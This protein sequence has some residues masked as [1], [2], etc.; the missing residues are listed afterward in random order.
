MDDME[1][2]MNSPKGGRARDALF[3][4][5]LD[6]VAMPASRLAHQDRNMVGDILL[7]MLFHATTEERSLCASRLATSR[8]APRRLLRYL[9]QCSFEIAQPLLEQNEAFDACDL[10]EIVES[11]STEHRMAIA[12]RKVVAPGVSAALAE[13]GEPHVVREL[14]ANPGALLPESALDKLL[15]R[16]RDESQLCALMVERLELRPSQAMAMFWW[17][18]GATRRKILQRH[19]ADRLEVIETCKDVFEMMAAEKWA[20]PVARKALQLIERRQRNREALERSPFDSLES[21]IN[22]AAMEGMNAELAQE[23]GYLCGIK[24]VTIAKIL[25]DNGGEGLAVL[26]KATGVKR[27]FLPVLWASLRRPL[28]IDNDEMHPQF[29]IVAETY[30][31]LT[32]AKAQTTLRYWNWSL[33][34]AFSPQALREA[35]ASGAPANEEAAFSTSQRTARLVFGS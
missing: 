28:E 30:E 20:D 9:A 3:R 10:S 4:R 11:T 24:P 19:A 29:A 21:A 35:Q 15:T 32:V 26:C 8:E 16:S 23:I 31:I 18:D 5:L 27:D 2:Q 25:S 22:S 14:V 13:H 7:D 34:S 17:S 12:R 6:L 1:A 33:S